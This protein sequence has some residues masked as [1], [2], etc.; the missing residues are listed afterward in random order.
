[1]Q[2]QLA[3]LQAQFEAVNA[4]ANRAA[5]GPAAGAMQ[6]AA[7]S[8]QVD[9]MARAFTNAANATGVLNAQEM[10]VASQTGKY[11]ELLQK[12]KLS[13][14]QLISDRKILNRVYK[15]QLALE[16]MSVTRWGTDER[17][18]TR[19]T[20]AVPKT[21]LDD[22]DTAGRRI[23]F[24]REQT[25]SASQAMLNWG[26]N[27]QW[28]GRQLMVGFTMPIAAFGAVAG[29]MAY[30][31]DKE[32]T[33]IA[34]VY[35]THARGFEAKERELAV[36]RA[37][38]MH[39]AGEAARDYGT[40]LTDTLSVEA[41]LAAVGMR[42]AKLREATTE[43]VKNATLGEIEHQ[44]A[45]QATIA[46]Q[47]ILA[48]KSGETADIW[49]YMNSVENATSLGMKDFAEAI[50]RALGPMKSMS[51]EGASATEV[52]QN[53]GTLLVGMRSQGINAAE[54]ANAIK[55]MMQRLYRPSK[56]VKEEWKQLAGVNLEQM[57]SKTSDVMELLPKIGEIVSTLPQQDANKLLGGLFGTYQVQRISAMTKALFEG[58]EQVERVLQINNQDVEQWRN[59][60]AK[61]IQ[62]WQQSTSGQFKIAV[63]SIK[64][65]LAETGEPFLQAATW[66]IS[67][68]K[69]IIDVFNE[70]PDSVKKFAMIGMIVGGLAGGLIMVTG[71]FA[72]MLSWVGKLGVG[73]MGLFGR[74]KILNA[75]Q[76]MEALFAKE[77]SG[78]VLTEAE[79]MYMLR[80]Q[81]EGLNRALMQS[82]GLAMSPAAASAAA[83][84]S[85][86]ATAAQGRAATGG[87]TAAPGLIFLPGD[88]RNAERIEE[89]SDR[90]SRHAENTKKSWAGG[91]LAIA[92]MV[93]GMAAM[94]A[95]SGTAVGHFAE[96][97][98]YASM[99]T[100][101]MTAIKWKSIGAGLTS[102]FGIFSKGQGAHRGVG[103]ISSLFSGGLLK[104]MKGLVSSAGKF[105]L[106]LAKAFGPIGWLATGAALLFTMHKKADDAA[107]ALE[108]MADSGDRWAKVGGY[109]YKDPLA[110]IDPDTGEEIETIFDMAKKV[111]EEL[112]D[113]VESIA[114][115]G[116]SSKSAISIAVQQGIQMM[117]TGATKEQ[118]MRQIR[119]TLFA[120]FGD[121]EVVEDL[122]VKIRPKFETDK[123]ILQARLRN[124]RNEIQRAMSNQFE[125]TKS[126]AVFDVL[127]WWEPEK[128]SDAS[129]KA[130]EKSADSFA[131]A[132]RNS[133]GKNKISMAR[134]ME[135]FFDRQRNAMLNDIKTSSKT[136]E[137]II[138]ELG[139]KSTREL[140]DEYNRLYN[141]SLMGNDTAAN[142]LGKLG[143]A[144]EKAGLN[145]EDI[146]KNFTNIQQGS[147]MWV[148]QWG[149]AMGLSEE[150]LKNVFSIEDI[151]MRLG[152]INLGNLNQSLNV[153]DVTDPTGNFGLSAM[154]NMNK[155]AGAV[156]NYVGEAKD[157]TRDVT[158][159]TEKQK[160]SVD[161]LAK[162]WKEVD[163]PGALKDAFAQTQEDIADRVTNNFERRQEAALEAV[164]R[165]GERRM[166]A[167]DRRREQ[168][169]KAFQT[170]MQQM[171]NRHEAERV[172]M[173]D[174]HERELWRFDQ[175]WKI[176]LRTAESYYD[177]RIEKVN[178]AIQA[179][180]RAEAI[181]QRIFDA[182]MTRIQRLADMANIQIDFSVAMQ[183][184]DLD[185]AARIR[186]DA[187]AQV[188]GWALEDAGNR[189]AN[190]SERRIN[191]LQSRIDD[192][193]KERDARI[194]ALNDMEE[195]HRRRLEREQER[196][197]RALEKSQRRQQNALEKEQELWN[198]RMD[199]KQKA[200]EREVD[201]ERDAAEKIWDT[202][203][204]HMDRAIEKF[205]AFIPTN[206]RALKKHADR[207][208]GEYTKFGVK[209]TEKGNHWG[210]V[211]G[212][213]LSRNVREAAITI[214][215]DINWEAVGRK[216]AAGMI[217]GAF[218]MSLPEFRKWLGLSA[219]RAPSGAGGGGG[220]R[221]SRADDIAKITD[222]RNKERGRA[223]HSGG[224]IAQKYSGRTGIPAGAS[225]YPSEI[226]IRAKRDEY[227]VDGRTHRRLGTD[228]FDSLKKTAGGTTGLYSGKDRGGMGGRSMGMSGIMGA[229]MAAMLMATLK[230]AILTK[231]YEQMAADQAAGGEYRA[232]KAGR[233]G[234]IAFDAEQLRNAAIIASVGSSLGASKRDIMIALMTAMVESMLRN[235]NYGDRDSLGLFQQRAPWA[236]AHI[237]M[238]PE[239]SARLFFLGGHGGDEPGLFDIKNRDSMSMGEAAQEVQRS[240]YPDRYAAMANEAR[241]I[242][243]AMKYVGGQFVPVNSKGKRY[244]SIEPVEPWVREAAEYVGAKHDVSTI[245]GFGYR[246]NVTDHDDG[247]ALD[248]MTYSNPRKGDA[249]AKT[250]QDMW[251]ALDVTYM[252]WK[253]RIKS[254]PGGR[255]DQME[256]RG[257]RTA[258]HMDHVHVSFQKV[259]DIDG[260][261]QRGMIG[262]TKGRRYQH[263]GRKH[264]PV[265]AGTPMSRG[266]AVHDGYTQYPALDM[267]GETGDPIFA[268]KNG[269]VTSTRRMN[270]SYGNHIYIM[271]PEGFSTLYAHLKNIGVREGQNV[272]GGQVIG[273]MGSTGYSTGSHLHFGVNSGPGGP[274]PRSFYPNLNVGGNIRWDNTI[275]N[276]HKGETVLTEPL[277]RELERGIK[278]FA[279]GG[280]T[281]YNENITIN[282]APGMSPEAIANAVM[283]KL[284]HRNSRNGIRR[285]INSR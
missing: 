29:G 61:E 171:E 35:D 127:G 203:R 269:R 54:G 274:G 261:L 131:I 276:L 278:N 251:R 185:E 59:V 264:R 99:L 106:H 18:R 90:T 242:L 81:V 133:T 219:G 34:K 199:K 161:A 132:F 118:A 220:G 139:I 72:N 128:L 158:E 116:Q 89:A 268:V 184:G 230:Q 284:E 168:R 125:R 152:M 170:E 46:I 180:E 17:G 283:S 129:R 130:A 210:K 285:T 227:V 55:S 156:R 26:K 277:S 259:G 222:A 258:N 174:E 138:K 78:A 19:A 166:E 244:P 163:V 36:V 73:V 224:P 27:T 23:G 98:L 71:L 229:G 143:Q 92:G 21:A 232:A 1:M 57:V 70:L 83:R 252:I 2:G 47:D 97:V 173:D 64:V 157:G 218:G 238:D 281:V 233:Y 93:G 217:S 114:A 169:E 237:R 215:S 120:A 91:K 197:Q 150:V 109:Q 87:S 214:K 4:A 167:F 205:L 142:Q 221:N 266:G 172:R 178:S 275:A 262:H 202:R 77:A 121:M 165:A 31:A 213:A 56:Q 96:I 6:Y 250:I 8:K 12:Q 246:G 101:L 201:A 239:K 20:V 198:D 265:R 272:R 183:S 231:G 263:G 154:N 108:R 95:F 147:L 107:E 10:R 58:G 85:V 279:S 134:E 149:R 63:E 53:L 16:R 216:S 7:V 135:S 254:S 79:S 111:N 11:T 225:R 204:R 181:R 14:R 187:Q 241:A 260:L 75:E 243:N 100:P 50:P 190:R 212:D 282:P 194:E 48:T 105:V 249:I 273:R 175:R 191:R 113:V 159:E 145:I 119:A 248:F 49:A 22:L 209:V 112:P 124:V 223:K 84:G 88:V 94:T 240:A 270:T 65:S 162:A 195:R 188:E 155:L 68:V 15:E 110:T 122:M 66:A 3:S 117:D 40:S 39:L 25:R 189:G 141:Q 67:S 126:E 62:K 245:Y 151:L 160:K 257:S 267:D 37:E 176:R 44:T 234:D 104:G 51:E 271:H 255:W 235:V 228:Y 42:G 140:I 177:T 137:R 256:N 52:M 5:T 80:A 280:N 28:A 186:N 82:Q 236:P 136:G 60:Q 148:R 32:L 9:G 211:V 115:A 74:M 206:E 41:D 30:Q 207:T 164:E 153:I 247:L 208:L 196:E 144:M 33:R 43:V 200:L 24:I 45:M 226:D 86:S 103:A 13:L 146:R 253:Q 179:E 102:V 123:T 69:R 193:E 192:I 38:A 182:E 76:R